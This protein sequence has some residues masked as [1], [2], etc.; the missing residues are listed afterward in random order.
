M[1]SLLGWV[2][3]FTLLSL[4]CCAAPGICLAQSAD[5][6]RISSVVPAD[7]PATGG[8]Q[9]SIHGS[10]F[11]GA[12]GVNFGG[13]SS[14]SFKVIS[15]G[16]VDAVL[17]PFPNP[18][19]IPLDGYQ[20][21]AAVCTA[22]GCSPQ[23]VPGNFTYLRKLPIAHLA[24][25]SVSLQ[26]SPASISLG[27]S[28]TLTWSATRT[29]NTATPCSAS[30]AGGDWFG[31]EPASGST[32]L[33]PLLAGTKTYTLT[34]NGPGGS[35]SANTTLTV[36]TPPPPVVSLQVSPT[37]ISLGSSATLTWSATGTSNTATPCS[38]SS[39]G[40][41]WSGSEPASGSATLTPLLAGTK[42]YT[43]T[44]NGTGG[45]G[46]ASATLTVSTPPPPV[47]SLQVSPT[48]ISLGNSAT[49]TWSAT[50][51]SNTATP[52]S[53]SSAGGD[54]SGS[55]P[56]SGSATLTPLLA[57]SKTYTLTCSGPGGSGSASTSLTV[58]VP[59]PMFNQ[60]QIT[61]ATAGDDARQDDEIIA[62]L[63]GL[64]PICL[65]ASNAGTDGRGPNGAAVC[66]QNS[67]APSWGNWT[68]DLNRQLFSLTSNGAPTSMPSFSTM[69]I[70]LVQHPRGLEG[71]D[72][73][74]IQGISV[75]EINAQSG[76]PTVILNLGTLNNSSLGGLSAC[77]NRLKN[78][79]G[80]DTVTFQFA[81]PGLGPVG[82][83]SGGG[84]PC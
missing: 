84:G 77:I 54:W 74:N 33:T 49:L 42:T 66:P 63:P 64:D 57:G 75:S 45:S 18:K 38:A 26:V 32:T 56:A 5:A 36:S 31:S 60:L 21:N 72:N 62:T 65:K 11:T 37:S 30:S 48:S 12:T 23:Y 47:V 29:N 51:A 39:A 24:P 22:S 10:G 15:D 17:P 55:E 16:E 7:G 13:N 14:K 8:T 53:A 83:I 52:C 79:S 34:C 78:G 69:S 9:I 67:N 81:P 73:W 43:L 2:S 3:P 19:A 44:C 40:G 4:V 71:W 59:V 82:S 25:P 41:D 68:V 1:K 46:S 27:S 35:G 76:S 70:T 58:T 20:L 28:A 6:P 61:I 50:G 80:I